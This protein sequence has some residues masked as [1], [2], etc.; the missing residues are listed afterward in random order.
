MFEEEF[1]M[2]RNVCVSFNLFVVITSC[3]FGQV[4]ESDTLKRG[5]VFV[6]ELVCS[7]DLSSFPEYDFE[8]AKIIIP[9]ENDNFISVW[10]P[11]S[12]AHEEDSCKTT[13]LFF[14]GSFIGRFPNTELINSSHN[15]KFCILNEKFTPEGHV[16]ASCWYGEN[17]IIDSLGEQLCWLAVS[18]FEYGYTFWS[19]NDSFIGVFDG[20]H[21]GFGLIDPI[22]LIMDGPNNNAY[23][24]NSDSGVTV[25][26][27][28]ADDD[29]NG[30]DNSVGLFSKKLNHFY[31]LSFDS[32][33]GYDKNFNHIFTIPHTI[34]FPSPIESVPFGTQPVFGFSKFDNNIYIYAVYSIVGRSKYIPLLGMIL[35]TFVFW[36]QDSIPYLTATAMCMDTLGNIIWQKSTDSLLISCFDMSPSG[37]YTIGYSEL[38][39]C[40]YRQIDI[41]ETQANNLIFMKNFPKDT[42]VNRIDIYRKTYSR[43]ATLYENSLSGH[44]LIRAILQEVDT[45]FYLI[46]GTEAPPDISQITGITLCDD[47]EHG[48]KIDGNKVYIYKVSW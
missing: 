8:D 30:N 6:P 37:K 33:D 29:F 17:E 3:I 28:E 36:Y 15:G 21:S 34:D 46:D 40:G 1:F 48:Y 12:S 5:Y 13:F 42:F 47:L 39:D 44:L 27:F 45:S 22:F 9:K 26:T 4:A 7:L 10:A 19:E 14:K 38:S 11:P 18:P 2:Y 23:I 24:L 16:G 35:P 32:L 31:T 25:R 20:T 43:W 41:W